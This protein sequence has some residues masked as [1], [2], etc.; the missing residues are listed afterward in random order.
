MAHPRTRIASLVHRIAVVAA[1]CM[2]SN[3]ISRA[4]LRF[5]HHFADRD[6]A[7]A[8]WAKPIWPIWTATATWISSPASRTGGF[9]GTS[10]RRPTSGSGMT[11]ATIPRRTSAARRSTSTATAG[12]I[13]SP[14]ARGTRTRKRRG[15]RHFVRHVFDPTLAAVHDLILGDVDGDGRLDVLTMSDRNDVRW[16]KIAEKPHG[17]WKPHAD[18][19]AGPLG[20]LPGRSRQRRRPGRGSQQCLVREPGP[21]PA[22]DDAQ[23]DRAL[24]RKDPPFAVNATQTATT[25]LNRDGRLDVVI[26]DGENPSSKIAWLEAPADPRK[27]KWRTHP[28][29]RG[30]EAAARRTPLAPRRRFRQ[31]R[32]RR[33]FHRRNGTVSRRPAAAVVHLGKH[34]RQGNA[35]RARRFSTPISAATKPWSATSIATATSTSARNP[36]RRERPTRWAA[37]AT[38]TTWRTSRRGPKTANSA[39]RPAIH[40][41]ACAAYHRFQAFSS[42]P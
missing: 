35:R 22:V 33:Y 16:Y 25:D 31:R 24:G 30:D 4:E 13:S 1:I 17:R 18:R 23:D 10:I 5:R 9:F 34:R 12:S 42:N 32:R 3:E 21:R 8:I 14:A 7:A 20:H 38:S 11:W 2:L 19:R 37:K 26:C 27:G 28:L 39:A 15:R 40:P 29:P 36:G 41:C 6:L